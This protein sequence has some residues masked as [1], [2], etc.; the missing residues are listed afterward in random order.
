[1]NGSHIWLQLASKYGVKNELSSA[2]KGYLK[3]YW[4]KPVPKETLEILNTILKAKSK[5]NK[6]MHLEIL[7]NRIQLNKIYNLLSKIAS[8]K[9]LVEDEK[10]QQVENND[11]EKEL[12]KLMSELNKI[13]NKTNG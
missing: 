1:M 9:N 4:R 11:S 3:E 2:I 13:K 7:T 5:K 12:K 6:A 10:E 8:S